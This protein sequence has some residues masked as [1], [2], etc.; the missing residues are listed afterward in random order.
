ME[1]Q[2]SRRL[3]PE[4]GKASRRRR[5]RKL[6][7]RA[8]LAALALCAACS[9]CAGRPDPPKSRAPR[10]GFAM[11]TLK[12][13]RWYIDRTDFLAE[14]KK[15]GAQVTV[16]LA[17]DDGDEQLAQVRHLV[18]QGIDVLVIIPHDAT[19]AARCVSV[20][21]QAGVKVVSYDR[22]VR[23]A[24]CDLYI[25]F[26]N[27]E[28]GRLQAKAVLAAVPKGNYVI[29]EG[30]LSDYNVTMIRQG[31]EEELRGPVQD[32]RVKILKDFHTDDWMADEAAGGVESILVDGQKIDAVLAE[33]DGLAGGVIT[34]LSKFGLI[35]SVPVTG[36]DADLAACQRVMEGQQLMTVYKPIGKLAAAAA[37]FAVEYA[38]GQKPKV[39]GKIFD[40]RYT[41]PYYSIEPVAVNR[42]N[43]AQT[44]LRDGFHQVSQVYMN[45]PKSEWPAQ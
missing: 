32:G 20:A 34:T 16:E 3:S 29:A 27:V 7:L 25:S 23:D 11:D 36:M 6:S 30:P 8:L 41:V 43:M 24:G 42:Q 17:D 19:A 22:L 45:L 39:S 15:K 40:G 10:I 37:D 14:A 28:V 5:A 38:Q 26:D 4:T 31:M 18:A 2:P 9:G 35:P 21:K 13:E 12:E 33:N 44:V 1:R